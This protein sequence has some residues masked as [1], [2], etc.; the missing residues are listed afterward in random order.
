M[1]LINVELPEDLI[2]EYSKYVN[3]NCNKLEGESIFIHVLAD[4]LAY[5]SLIEN[6]NELL[7]HTKKTWYDRLIKDYR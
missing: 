2:K 3:M 6:L 7:I 1:K 4:A 5:R